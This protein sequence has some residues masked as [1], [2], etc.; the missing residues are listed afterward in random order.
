[1]FQVL[2]QELLQLPHGSRPP[3]FLRPIPSLHSV[4]AGEHADVKAK[5]RRRMGLFF[6]G[7]FFVKGVLAAYTWMSAP[8]FPTHGVAERWVPLKTLTTNC[9][10][11]GGDHV[12]G[13]R[14]VGLPLWTEA[15]ITTRAAHFNFAGC[16]RSTVC[17]REDVM[18][19]VFVF[20]I[21]Y[22][23]HKTHPKSRKF[24]YS[25]S[26]QICAKILIAKMDFVKLSPCSPYTW[27]KLAKSKN[28]DNT[29]TILY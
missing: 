1:M 14:R 27:K 7:F 5:R 12:N 22:R 18:H 28:I 17:S 11:M 16:L 29:S 9:R 20:E 8:T 21:M 15:A 23:C 24:G 4:N 3:H 19:G 6:V 25:K 10:L 26:G 13:G 2:Q